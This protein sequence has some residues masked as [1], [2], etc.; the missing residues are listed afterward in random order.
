MKRFQLI[1]LAA[2]IAPVSFLSVSPARA[3][4]CSIER[5]SNAQSFW[6][7]RLIDGR[8]CWYEGKPMLSK[9]LLAW[10]PAGKP[11]EPAS[12]AEPASDKTSTVENPIVLN[13][14][15]GFEARWRARFLDALG[16]Y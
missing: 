13:D 5:P 3:I 8:K 7:Y 11:A 1:V 10:P 4:Q 6:S 12:A 16:K 15:D 9:S 14:N 2:C